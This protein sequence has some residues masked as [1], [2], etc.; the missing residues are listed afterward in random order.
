MRK[1]RETRTASPSAATTAHQMPSRPQTAGSSSTMPPRSS[2]VRAKEIRAEMRPLHRAV[3]K[4][5]A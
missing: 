5:E 2:R 3:K 4:A 1:A